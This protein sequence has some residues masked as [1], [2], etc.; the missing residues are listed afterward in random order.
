MKTFE[1]T[2]TGLAT[3]QALA[4]A[5]DYLWDKQEHCARQSGAFSGGHRASTLDSALEAVQ[6]FRTFEPTEVPGIVRRGLWK[7]V[8]EVEERRIGLAEETHSPYDPRTLRGPAILGAAGVPS[9]IG[10]DDSG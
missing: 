6:R 1:T 4:H 8:R 3:D 5:R 7:F 10:R 9:R 2:D